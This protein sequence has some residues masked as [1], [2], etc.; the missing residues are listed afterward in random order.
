LYVEDCDKV[1]AQALAAGGIQLQ[2]LTDQFYGDRSGTLKDPFGNIWF[3]STHKEDLTRRDSRP[4]R[5]NVRRQPSGKLKAARLCLKLEA[6]SLELLHANHRQ[7]RRPGAQPDPAE[8]ELLVGFA[9]GSLA[10]PRLLQANQLLMKV[11]N[12]NQW[13]A[14][15]CR[16]DALPVLNVTLNGSTG[17]L[18]LE[19][20]RHRRARARLPV[21][22][23]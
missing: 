17:T 23:G 16:N 20:P 21:H 3:V 14:C 2:P 10:G 1:Y 12:A 22:Q 9:T 6:R 5:E 19:Q 15:D 13:L 18:F 8:E 4:R 7:N 11:R